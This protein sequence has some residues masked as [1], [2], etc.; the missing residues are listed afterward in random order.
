MPIIEL[1]KGLSF[2]NVCTV[3]PG[4]VIQKGSFKTNIKHLIILSILGVCFCQN[5]ILNML[6]TLFSLTVFFFKNIFHLASNRRKWELR[7]MHSKNV[8]CLATQP[9]SL[10]THTHFHTLSLSHTL[11]QRWILALAVQYARWL[12]ESCGLTSRLAATYRTLGCL[13]C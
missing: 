11:P 4:I 7:W 8:S 10:H 5:F 1:P 13:K 9:P 2:W 12:A 6:K 3:L